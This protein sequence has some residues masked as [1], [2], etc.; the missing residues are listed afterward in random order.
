MRL[1]ERVATLVEWIVAD[2]MEGL[3]AGNAPFAPHLMLLDDRPGPRDRTLQH[4][5]FGPDLAEGLEQAR[6]SVGPTTP[7]TAYAIAWDGY[8][9]V[10]GERSDAVLVEVGT[11][12]EPDAW[13]LAQPYGTV[14][15]RF[16]GS[17]TERHG[18]LLEVDRPGSRLADIVPVWPDRLEPAGIVHELAWTS[19]P[20]PGRHK[21]E[22]VPVGQ[23]VDA[24]TE[25]VLLEIDTRSPGASAWAAM[26]LDVLADSELDVVH[27]EAGDDGSGGVLVEFLLRTERFLEWNAQRYVDHPLGVVM[28]GVVRRFADGSGPTDRD[29]VLADLRAM[30]VPPLR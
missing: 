12:D 13:L 25:M 21:A 3:Q 18:D 1:P 19:N 16:R 14:A 15:R 11:G 23:Q 9:T 4:T 26:L 28:L 6:A 7:A 24:F 10:N 17:R 27:R 29:T 2:T 5:R 8:A 20:V 22:Y 30:P